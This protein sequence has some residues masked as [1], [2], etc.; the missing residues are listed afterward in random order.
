MALHTLVPRCPACPKSLPRYLLGQVWLPWHANPATIPP[1]RR[2]PV[3]IGFG[4]WPLHD[5]P[6]SK[7][8]RLRRRLIDSFGPWCAVCGYSYGIYL[9]HLTG[10]VRGLLCHACNGGV[11]VCPH[12]TGCPCADYLN[13][14]PALPLNLLHP[15]RYADRRR[16]Q[17][18]ID[19]Y[20]LDPYEQ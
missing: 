12:L 8:G 19:Y 20:G 6:H 15:A 5:N 13:D 4:H 3:G 11:E 10:L 17:W 2:C 14:P 18:K 7:C 1:R 16:D 9:D